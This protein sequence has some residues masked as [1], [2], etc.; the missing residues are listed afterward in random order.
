MSAMGQQIMLL[1]LSPIRLPPSPE[2]SQKFAWVRIWDLASSNAQLGSTHL[3]SALIKLIN[4]LTPS[5]SGTF[6]I[7]SRP[8]YRE[9]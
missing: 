9:M 3:P 8:R 1:S 6:L 4:S 5:V 2:K 7:S